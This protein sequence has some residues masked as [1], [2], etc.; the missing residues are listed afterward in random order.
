MAFV[1]PNVL[2]ANPTVPC[3]DKCIP[4]GAKWAVL[5]YLAAKWGGLSTDPAV[6]LAGNIECLDKCISPGMQKAVLISL[7]Q[8]IAGI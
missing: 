7:A 1:D 6:L 2:L 5:I 4:D 3:L 8:G